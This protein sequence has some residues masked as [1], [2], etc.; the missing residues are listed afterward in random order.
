VFPRGFLYW[1]LIAVVICLTLMTLKLRLSS[2]LEIY[3]FACLVEDEEI[4]F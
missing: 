4:L 2:V 3:L 1:V